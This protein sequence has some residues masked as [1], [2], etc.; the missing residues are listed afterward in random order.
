[1]VPLVAAMVGVSA[2]SALAQLY[3]SEKANRASKE[4][5]DKIEALFNSMVPP[6][7]DLSIIDPPEYIEQAIPPTAIDMT[8]ITPEQ[9][10]LVGEF[11]PEMAP[12]IA[13]AAPQVV[14]DSEAGI[15]GKNA[16][17]SALRRLKE[18][19][20]GRD[21]NFDA[22]INQLARRTQGEAGSRDQSILRGAE[23]RGALTSGLTGAA[24]LQGGASAMDRMANLGVDA[25]A[26]SQ[27]NALMALRDSGQLGRDIRGDD[28]SLAS[29]N[30]GII[31][32]YNQRFSR[33]YQNYVQA[34]ADMKNQAQMANLQAEQGIANQN[35][36]MN[37]RFG[38]DERDRLDDAAYKNRSEQVSER[39]YENSR[40]KALYDAKVR[41]Q[42]SYNTNVGNVA[43]WKMNQAQGMAG[44]AGTLN[45]HDSQVA[46]DRN[47]ALS[48]V[49]QAGV[50][51]MQ[52]TQ[53][54]ET[55]NQRIWD[56]RATDHAQKYGYYPQGGEIGT[57]EDYQR[58]WPEQTFYPID[59]PRNP[60]YKKP[61]SQ[62]GGG[63][64]NGYV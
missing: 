39:D 17:L 19:S 44:I 45:A 62:G 59:D 31:N 56:Q 18:V 25:A 49:A 16:S 28:L 7:Y 4:R 34:R 52:Q 21:P 40:Q 42:D 14:Q 63:E 37:N 30:T 29:K 51:G 9:Y 2:V 35:V 43:N 53:V 57:P 61:Q 26:E 5:L 32:D 58:S 15:E 55:N 24:Q 47:K 23:E 1:M 41:G 36:G 10:Q 20:Q 50:Q 64:P 6:E 38:V 33:D 27:R 8:K 3:Q 48:S 11:L 22:K 13:E 54:D 46:Q 12:R 60:R